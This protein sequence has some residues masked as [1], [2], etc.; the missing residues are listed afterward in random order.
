MRTFH[1]QTAPISLNSIYNNVKG[2]G[3]V[4]TKEYTQW[5]NAVLWELKAQNRSNMPAVT[6]YFGI[7]ISFC[8]SMTRADID[9]LCKPIIDCL[10][11]AGIVPDDRKLERLSIEKSTDQGVYINI[12]DMNDEA[13]FQIKEVKKQK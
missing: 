11:K 2:R 10:V 1:L 6:G 12:Y 7:D 13:L 9:N 4:K 3:R 5:I 8:R